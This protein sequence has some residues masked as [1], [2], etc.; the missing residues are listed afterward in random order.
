MTK[1]PSAWYGDHWAPPHLA[2]PDVLHASGPRA[3]ES[4][5]DAERAAR[6]GVVLGR[7]RPPH[8]GHVHLVEHAFRNCGWLHVLSPALP[9]AADPQRFH[10]RA[11]AAAFAELSEAKTVAA[12]LYAT[13]PR[14]WAPIVSALRPAPTDLF[15]SDPGADALARELGLR[16]HV[17]DAAR[18]T[19]PIS[20]T[21]IRADLA[22]HLPHVAPGAR[23]VF[24][25]SVGL[26]G[27]EGSGKTT[28]A[29][30]LGVLFE[31]PV[32]DDALRD[33]GALLLEG[34]RHERMRRF[35]RVLVTSPGR[36]RRAG[37]EAR[38]GVVLSD[39][40]SLTIGHWA[41]RLGLL[42]D[43]RD[44]DERDLRLALV[45]EARDLWLLC[46]GDFY[47]GPDDDVTDAGRRRAFRDAL[48]AALAQRGARVVVV[49]GEGR[50]RVDVAAAAI[51][52]ARAEKLAAIARAL[53]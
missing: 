40:T 48:H 38:T 9:E 20:S 26:V 8:V 5:K 51:R 10:A 41:R 3:D 16:H 44:L 32:V 1:G 47:A 49:A 33:R 21:M 14:A 43:E 53:A 42:V 11:V 30:E 34:S 52:A 25:L 35:G 46:D 28:L 29:R 27:A 7:F 12:P 22:T 13:D 2:P 18:V 39:D 50:A 6:V 45:P 31:A 36:E 4:P 15:S 23:A 17:V 24:A 19:F 37:H